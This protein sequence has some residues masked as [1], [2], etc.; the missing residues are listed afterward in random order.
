MIKY[1]SNKKCITKRTEI[2]YYRNKRNTYYKD[3]IRSYVELQ[4]KLEALEE[5]FK[6][7]DSEIN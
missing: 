5:N 7:N 2:N 6:L 3:L 1:Q 4:N